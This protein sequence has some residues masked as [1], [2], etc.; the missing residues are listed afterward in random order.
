MLFPRNY[1]FIGLNIVRA[2]SIIGL[3]LVFS[4]SIFV[5][6]KDIQAVNA[7]QQGRQTGNST[8][9]LHCEYIEGSTVPNQAAGVFWAILNRLLII[10]QV[11]MLFLSEL[12]WPRTFFER[13]FPVLGP[14]FGLGALGI[15]QALIGATVLSHHV[16]DFTLVSAFFLFSVGCL[17]M[18]L[19]L[20]FRESAKPKRSI[21]AYRD[22]AKRVLPISAPGHLQGGTFVPRPFHARADSAGDTAS[23]HSDSSSTLH[24]KV[25]YGFGFGRQAEKAAAQQGYGTQKPAEAVPRYARPQPRS[26][27]S[28]EPT[29]FSS[30]FSEPSRYSHASA[31]HDE[32]IPP[33][34]KFQSSATAI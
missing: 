8:V 23:V 6:V 17:N 14:E 11:V 2:L 29:A 13:F 9:D 20:V 34:P 22:G 3:I 31:D 33:V 24:E 10:F 28:P 4:S 16:D 7:F 26:T 18:L 15:F 12:G 21:A 19:G 27:R 5:V 30:R 32:E 1:I 25:G